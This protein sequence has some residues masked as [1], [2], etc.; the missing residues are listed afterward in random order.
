[1]AET[2][3]DGQLRVI[4]QL[5]AE[6]ERLREEVEELGGAILRM[7]NNNSP[8]DAQRIAEEVAERLYGEDWWKSTSSIPRTTSGWTG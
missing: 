4:E 7:A 2:L 8:H 5:R 1:M 6:N 3:A